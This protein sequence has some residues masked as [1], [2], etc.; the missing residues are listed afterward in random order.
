MGAMKR[1]APNPVMPQFLAG[2]KPG[3]PIDKEK[4]RAE[5]KAYLKL[6]FL[7]MTPTQE[8]FVRVKNRF[9]RM[10]KT[11]LMEMGNQGGKTTIGISED[12]AHAMGFRPWLKN[13][14]PDF[15]IPIKVPNVG[16][17]GCEVAGQ[18]LSQRIEPGFMELIPKYCN[19]QISRYSDGSLKSLML[20]FDYMG[21]PCGSTIHFR[22]YVQPSESYEGIISDWIH[23]DEPPPRAILNAAA[24]GEM[25]TNG[26]SWFTMTP[27]KEPYIYDLFSLKAFNNGGDDQEIAVFR[28]ATWDNCQDWCRGCNLT[29]EAN[30]PE[31]IAPGAARPVR[32][33]PGC[34]KT[35]GFMPRAGI[36][37]YLKKITDPD[38]REAREEGKWKHL[39]GSVY[40]EL[41]RDTHL[42]PDFEI[43]A[44]WM[45]IEVVDPHDAKPTR[46]LFGAVSP[47]EISIAGKTAN[48][49][50]WYS[51]LLLG[52]TLH[53]IVRRVKVHRA[54]KVYHHP[55]MVILD[56]KYGARTV[57]TMENETSWE[58][59][60]EKAGI[61]G[62][63]LSHSAP[64]DVSLGHKAVKDYLRP[65]YSAL[66]GKE[67][68]GMLFATQGCAGDRGPIQDAFNYRWK[69]GSDKPEEDFKDFCDCFRYAALEQ[70]VYKMPQPEIDP[71]LA[72]M[73]LDKGDRKDEY[74]PL[75]YGLAL[76]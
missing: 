75:E 54:E 11:R 29:I 42:Y 31:N 20:P 58:E 6:K 38:E 1:P 52:G 26:P 62:I 23:W 63:V 51:Y 4:V 70:P 12:I 59:E 68:P 76:K 8:A 74:N 5:I 10:P 17:V 7:Q 57:K 61:H 69:M 53:E 15:K 25:S 48:R 39:S 9:G 56:A 2:Y 46:W 73:L 66:R 71:A 35:M 72:K 32:R 27:L 33:C 28:G 16:M 34:R 67:I 47:E 45:R 37:N 43:P 49:I 50:Y 13:T 41:S 21:N 44:D 18:T 40:K 64:G 36:E 19:P 14:D 30:Q 22:S 3:D 24:R 60:L 55:E 65:Q